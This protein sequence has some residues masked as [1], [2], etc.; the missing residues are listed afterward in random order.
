MCKYFILFVLLYRFTPVGRASFFPTPRNDGHLLGGGLVNWTGFSLIFNFGW[1][2]FVNV[3]L[4][5]SAFILGRSVYDVLRDLLIPGYGDQRQPANPA[6]YRSWTEHDVRKAENLIRTCQVK[7]D[8]PNGETYKKR[9]SAVINKPANHPDHHFTGPN[10]DTNVEDYCL[11]VKRYRIQNRDGICL[12]L[13]N[14]IVPAEVRQTFIKPIEHFYLL[15]SLHSFDFQVCTI[16]K[17]QVFSQKLEEAQT[18]N[19]IRNTAKPPADRLVKIEESI[20][21]A[22]FSNDVV[23]KEFGVSVLSQLQILSARVLPRPTLVYGVKHH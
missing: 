10:G 3:D 4:A 20:A 13:G 9:I 8:W 23:L 6:D 7:Y 2:P 1:K 22:E 12:K 16:I 18:S 11:N 21:T 14:A 5:N 15:H 19:M 17:G